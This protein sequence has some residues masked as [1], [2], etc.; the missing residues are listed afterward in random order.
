[1]SALVRLA[2]VIQTEELRISA[3]RLETIYIQST[4]K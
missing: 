2:W 4:A 1:M 3:Y